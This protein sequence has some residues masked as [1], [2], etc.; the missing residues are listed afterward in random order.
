MSGKL[1]DEGNKLGQVTKSVKFCYSA[2]ILDRLFG[3]DCSPDVSGHAN[4]A[5]A[6]GVMRH[7]DKAIW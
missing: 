2:H 7:S 5:E 1:T 6:A 3:L 4:E